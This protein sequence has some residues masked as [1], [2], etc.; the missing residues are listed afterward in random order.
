MSLRASYGCPE[1][2]AIGCVTRSRA[3][4]KVTCIAGL[5]IPKVDTLWADLDGEATPRNTHHVHIGPF[6]R[7]VDCARYG[8]AL[9]PCV[10]S[11]CFA[12]HHINIG[13]DLRR[14]PR[15]ILSRVE[16]RL[17]LGVQELASR[18]DSVRAS[19]SGDA[20]G[21]QAGAQMAFV[22]ARA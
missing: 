11:R 1:S 18:S 16:H 7:M 9:V 2:S 5:H 15:L 22:A 19:G 17:G 20:V 4:Y 14:V 6:G 12:A 13:R 8:T 3:S 10:A 21:S